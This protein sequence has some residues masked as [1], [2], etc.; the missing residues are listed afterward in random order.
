MARRDAEAQQHPRTCSLYIGPSFDSAWE[1]I[2]WPWLD[3]ILSDAWKFPLP[4]LVIVPTRGQVNDL[5]ARLITKGA[6]HLGVQFV[7]PASLRTL[8]AREN[9]EGCG[10]PEHLRLLFSVAAAEM[11]ERPNESESLAAQSVT[12]APA[13]LLRT[14]NRLETAGW[15][16]NDLPVASFAPVVERFRELCQ[17]C[18]FL[19]PGQE[20]KQHL[21][22]AKT[23]GKKFSS[24]LVTGFDGSHWPDW[25]LLRAAVAL[26]SDPTVVHEEP[27]GDFSEVDLCWIGSWEEIC[28]EAK[29]IGTPG[30]MLGDS[31]FSEAEMRGGSDGQTQFDFLIG[32][33]V[34][35]QAE[36]I[37]WQCVRYLAEDRCARLGVI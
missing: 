22:R 14:L 17:Q 1:T 32:T 12:R 2:V 13:P 28:G 21:R 7:T 35:E 5:K 23:D 36:A 16:F 33:N 26:A 20:D 27:R 31:L 24:V 10:Q 8:L 9:A 15:K 4:S 18:R 6:S 30:Q 11:E 25:F 29:Q 34:S 19:L 37:A 3:R